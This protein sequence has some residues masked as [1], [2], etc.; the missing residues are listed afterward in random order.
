MFIN[1]RVLFYLKKKIKFIIKS[2]VS[3]ENYTVREVLTKNRTRVWR[4]VY[5]TASA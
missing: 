5:N 1:I 2:V 3:I 4:N